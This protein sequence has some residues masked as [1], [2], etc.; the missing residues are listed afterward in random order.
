MSSNLA[1]FFI[2]GLLFEC[3]KSQSI[4][5]L[6]NNVFISWTNKGSITSF[7]AT[8]NIGNGVSVGDVWFGIGLN[9][10]SAMVFLD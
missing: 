4:N 7:Y 9:N 5:F 2:L 1:K 6:N 10:Q 8:A 3:S